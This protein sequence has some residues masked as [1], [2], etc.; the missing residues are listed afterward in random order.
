VNSNFTLSNNGT[1]QTQLTDTT[2]D[3]TKHKIA[4]AATLT[5]DAAAA[6]TETFAGKTGTLV[7]DEASEFDG[8]VSGF[9]GQDHLDLADI[10]FGAHSTLGY[11]ANGSNGGTLTVSDG[12]HTA[13]IALL[14]NYIA[15]SF[16]LT[17]DGHGGSLITPASQMALEQPV[18]TQSPHA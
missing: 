5:I 18:L 7:L 8:K 11:A 1:G 10:G 4:P 2:F 3:I 14:G 17:S 12:T 13:N 16:T 15:S 6:G 9:S